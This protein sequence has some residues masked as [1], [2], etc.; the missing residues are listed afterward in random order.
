MSDAALGCLVLIGVWLMPLLIG[1][2]LGW[3][4]A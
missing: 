4:L 3:W 1:F 2:A